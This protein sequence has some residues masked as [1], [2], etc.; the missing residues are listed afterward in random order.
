MGTIAVESNLG[1]WPKQRRGPALGIYQIE[2]ATKDDV[3]RYAKRA[4]P[5]LSI[6]LLAA[7]E[8]ALV[9]DL[10]YATIIARLKYWMVPEPL[11]RNRHD[12]ANYWKKH[13]NTCEGKGQIKDFINH[14]QALFT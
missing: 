8:D 4:F 10:R 7:S 11:P 2:P 13:Y 14:A 3:V 9:Y 6:Y 5:L 12:M 1:Y